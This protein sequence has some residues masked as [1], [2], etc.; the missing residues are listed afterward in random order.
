MIYSEICQMVILVRTWQNMGFNDWEEGEDMNIGDCEVG[1]RV[2]VF[3]HLGVLE[4]L[5]ML[6]EVTLTILPCGH[7]IIIAGCLFF[8]CWSWNPSPCTC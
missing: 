2:N 4:Q 1:R 8:Q 3:Q 5:G 7:V 6:S